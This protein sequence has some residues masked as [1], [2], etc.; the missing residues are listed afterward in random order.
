MIPYKMRLAG[1]PTD[2][3]SSLPCYPSQSSNNLKNI[4]YLILVYLVRIT[5]TLWKPINIVEILKEKKLADCL[6]NLIFH[7]HLS[8]SLQLR[9]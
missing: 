2:V 9:L 3:I 7:S 4:I 8:H 1:L 6:S 5:S